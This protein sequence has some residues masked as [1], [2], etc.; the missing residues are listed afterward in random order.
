MGDFY[1]HGVV[2]TLHQL[3]NRPIEAIE[4]ELIE[5]GKQRPM[6]LLLPSLFSEL[7]G[8]ALSNIVDELT[9]VPY[10]E[11]IIVGLD[12]AD[13]AQYRHA[14]DFFNRLPQRPSIMW[15]DGPRLREIDALRSF[16]EGKPSGLLGPG[17]GPTKWC[18]RSPSSRSF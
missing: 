17:E 4:Q 8:P 10:L 3:S 6:A 9:Q 12:R 1:Q 14:L 11:Q 7:E 18:S 13:E 15:H 2:T 5:F 16:A